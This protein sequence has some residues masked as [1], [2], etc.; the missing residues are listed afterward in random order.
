VLALLLH[1]GIDTMLSVRFFSVTMFVGLAAF[2]DARDWELFARLG[3]ARSM[4]RARV[5]PGGQR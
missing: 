4:D 2:L 5:A 1:V 3:R